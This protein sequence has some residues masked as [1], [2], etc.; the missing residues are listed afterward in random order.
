MIYLVTYVCVVA[1][2]L[3]RPVCTFSN[4]SKR[5]LLFLVVQFLIAVDSLVVEHRLLGAWA[6]VVAAQ[7]FAMWLSG[8]R[9]LAQKL[10]SMGFD[11]SAA[12]GI[13]PDQGANPCPLT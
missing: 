4:C 5:G 3:H 11:C 12:C 7:G 13:F 8:S 9:N 6:L 2:A 10:C 1:L